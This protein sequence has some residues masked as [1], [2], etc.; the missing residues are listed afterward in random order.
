MTGS[1]FK[2][3]ARA[4]HVGSLLRP[5]ELTR[6]FKEHHAGAIDDAA[7]QAAQ[8]D[9]IRDVIA[10]QEAAGLQAITDGEFRRASYWARFVERVDGLEVRDAVFT[11]HDDCGHETAFTAPHVT[12]PVRRSRPIAAD[13]FLFVRDHTGRTP[14][15]TL[16]SPPT[17]HFWRLDKSI[18]PGIYADKAA[19]F[20]DLA[21]VFRQEIAHLAERGC[22]YVQCDD[23]PI[24][25]LCDPAIRDRVAEAGLDPAQLL[26]DYIGLFADCLAGRPDGMVA[27]IHLC[28]GNFKGQF[29]SEGGYEDVAAKLFNDIPADAFFLEYDTDRAGDFAPLRLVPKGRAVVLGLV[30]SKSPVL[31][32]EDDLIRRI[33][34]AAD[35]IDRDQ[36]AISPQCGF[37]STVGGNPVTIDDEKAKLDLIVRVADRA[38]N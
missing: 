37:A 20:A 11:F 14:K 21:A 12:A 3:P 28:R 35:Y 24:A 10:L 25:M 5:Q 17:M 16:P 32:D 7:F 22:R 33:D 4:D 1:T 31:E 15:I 27:A 38:W 30:S 29:L 34:Q 36:L 18:E 8:D 26:D 23:V 9:A 2:L 19:Y 13:E 6:A